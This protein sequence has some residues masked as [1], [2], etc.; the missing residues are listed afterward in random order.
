MVVTLGYAEPVD[1]EF[2]TETFSSKIGGKPKWLDPTRPLTVDKVLCDEC[3]RPMT[4]L[5]QLYAPEDEPVEAF[6]RTL[7]V[8]ICRNGTCHR[9]S[10][11]RCMRVYRSQIAEENDIYEEREADNDDDDVE[12]VMS[13][14]A[15]PANAC[16][17]CGL[18]GTKACSKCHTTYYCSREHQ[19]ADWEAGHRSQCNGEGSAGRDQTA[20]HKRRLVRMLYPEQ[21]IASEEEVFEDDNEDEGSDDDD[22]DN[23][24]I[25]AEDGAI[26][27]VSNEPVEDSHVDVDRAFLL[28]QRRIQK[29]SDQV[30]RYARSPDATEQPEPLFV[31]DSNKPEHGKDVPKCELCGA[32]REFEFQIM[33]QMLNF[34]SIDSVDPTSVDWGTLLVYSCPNSCS[35]TDETGRTSAYA[36]EAVC[37]QNFSSQGIGENWQVR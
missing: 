2:L 28:F 20:E 5:M 31:S 19:I 23:E 26:V 34:L 13:P 37:R 33:P 24:G 4:L 36:Q 21:V 8:F 6:H 18:A 35:S 7:Y 29:N 14:N 16:T 30:I 15:N 9:S 25:T 3:Q 12:W 22:E 27:P 10:A 32:D 1:D 11:S 17:V